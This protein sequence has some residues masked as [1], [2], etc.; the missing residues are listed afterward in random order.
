MLPTLSNTI[1]KNL[2]DVPTNSGSDTRLPA[3]MLPQ[4]VVD[5]ESVFP[6]LKISTDLQG[7]DVG[8]RWKL[9]VVLD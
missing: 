6:A 5:G 4:L 1:R 2:H 8:K 9:D 7:A 3:K